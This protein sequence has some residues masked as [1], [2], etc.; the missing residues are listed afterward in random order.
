M[1]N[2]LISLMKYILSSFL[3]AF[4]IAGCGG[5]GGDSG[6]GEA[7]SATPTTVVT[8]SG[9]VSGTDICVYDDTV[10]GSRGCTTATGTGT[11]KT[12][13]IALPVPGSYR[14]YLKENAGLPNETVYP[15]YQGGTN[16]FAFDSSVPS[17][18]DLGFV[19]TV[20]GYAVPTYGF[21]GPGV[22]VMPQIGAVPP[23]ISSSVFTYFDIVG[24]WQVIGLSTKNGLNSWFRGSV[25]I[26]GNGNL[27]WSSSTTFKNN[28][29]T[30]FT[31]EVLNVISSGFVASS[32]SKF[33]GLFTLNKKMIVATGTAPDSSACLYI[34]LKKDKSNYALTDLAGAS[35]TT[36]R[37][38]ML[39]AGDSPS[40]TGW[41]RGTM[42]VNNTG[43]TTTPF[44]DIIG[45]TSLGLGTL[46]IAA[47]GGITSST[48][49]SFFGFLSS[50][51][52]TLVYGMNDSGGFGL[53]IS[54]KVD[55]SAIYSPANLNGQW[56]GNFIRTSDSDTF[57]EWE[58]AWLNLSGGS[59]T[60]GTYSIVDS[61]S[62]S[63]SYTGAGTFTL[64]AGGAFIADGD[65]S[66]LGYVNPD[67]NLIIATQTENTIP[68]WTLVIL[69]KK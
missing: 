26:D 51:G 68:D 37:T 19:H 33:R 30:V 41:V 56:Y 62:P 60:S 69:L 9:T 61:Q 44:T 23:A 17:T 38:Q 65:P 46:T 66:S 58:R 48:V 25:S 15:L 63:G 47:D 3:V 4:I 40:Y 29:A 42:T 28:V 43:V 1:S 54:H 31:N 7:P 21:L 59:G 12:F 45:S 22:T 10:G 5:G 49:S 67:K 18:L 6:G 53:S 34:M 8:I 57:N 36:W 24:A 27:T 14:I 35:G 50:D 20:T 64:D 32:V 13:S 16:A 55:A 2:L 11:S 39:V 52:K